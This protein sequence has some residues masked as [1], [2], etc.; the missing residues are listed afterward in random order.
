[1]EASFA[2][3]EAAYPPRIQPF[4]LIVCSQHVFT[5]GDRLKITVLTTGS[6]AFPRLSS[7]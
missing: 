7:K 5:R 1:V 4:L 2:I 6:V 3:Y